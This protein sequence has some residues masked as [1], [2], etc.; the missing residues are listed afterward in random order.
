M[1]LFSKKEYVYSKEKISDL[2]PIGTIIKR[3]ND[4]QLYMIYSYIVFEKSKEN[5]KRILDVN[6][7]CFQY[8]IGHLPDEKPISIKVDEIAET[9][10]KGYD[11]NERKTFCQEMDKIQEGKNE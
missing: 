11:S 6:Y 3:E 8:P 10:F 1:G 7:E 2:M 5:N 9:I 4:N